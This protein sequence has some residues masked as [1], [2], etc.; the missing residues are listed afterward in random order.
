MTESVSK[1]V[2]QSVPKSTTGSAKK[3]VQDAVKK[4]IVGID[5]GTTNTV[6]AYASLAQQAGP[7]RIQLLQIDQLV[8]PGQ[9]KASALLPSVRYHGAPGEFAP[10]QCDLPWSQDGA[11]GAGEGAAVVIGQFARKLGAQV[12]GRLVVSAKSWL[13]HAGVDRLAPILPWGALLE[14]GKVSPVAASASYL[15]HVR[16]CW[17]KQFPDHPLA[18]QELVLTV[19]ASFDEGA[20]VLTLAAARQAGLLTL[21]LLEEPQAVFYDWLFR[22]QDT[23]AADL[24]STRLVL[25][26][27]VG[28]GT[29]DLSLIEVAL[30]DGAPQLTRVGVGNHLMLGG[31]NMDLAL[32]HLAE[33]RLNALNA[34]AAGA[35]AAPARL[36]AGE[37]SQLMER[38][39]AAKELLLAADAPQ[40]A[41]VTLL[42]TGNKL[43]KGARTVELQRAEVAALIVD[44]F[45]PVVERGDLAR[46]GRAGLVE[47]GLPY[48]SDPA[49]TRH[50]ATFLQQQ[51]A[52]LPA[53]L[54]DTLLLNGGVFRADALVRR[55]GDT[56]AAWRGAPLQ[57]LHN[58]DTEV[59][60]ARGA[61]A[62]AIAGQGRAPRIVGGAARSYF[63]VLGEDGPGKKTAAAMTATRRAICVLPRGSEAGSEI[64]LADHT[65]ALRI[66]QPVRFHLVSSTTGR[67]PAAG[68]L[69]AL[70][71]PDLVALPPIAL[72]LQASASGSKQEVR[73]QLATA[74]TELGTLELHC[75]EIKPDGVADAAP[76]QRWLLEFQLRGEHAGAAGL[77]P[78]A[79]EANMPGLPAAIEKIERIFGARA[80]H[81]AS[82]EVKQLRLQLEQLL[83]S[84]SHWSTPL[85][86]QLFDVLLARARGRRR[87]IEHERT[88]LNLAGYCLRPGFG[89]P[90]DDWRIQQLWALFEHGV[91]HGDD[92]AVCAEWW[93]LWRRVA[94]GLDAPSQLRLL[95]DFACNVQ[96]GEPGEGATAVTLVKG[97]FDDMLRLVAALERIP[98]DYKAEIGVWLLGKLPQKDDKNSA[99]EGAK[100]SVKSSANDG[101]KS[102]TG[103]KS[104]KARADDQAQAA[105]VLW[106]LGR[107]GARVPFY[108]NA[109]DVVA[110]EIVAIWLETMLALDWKRIDAAAFASAHIAR[111]SGDR[112]RDIAPALREHLIARLAA[113]A[114]APSWIAMVREVVELDLDDQRR[115]LGE[116]LPP[117]LTLIA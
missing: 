29:T 23:L 88:W 100:S 12:P 105:R 1:S 80:Q 21:R 31:D 87:S 61:V 70:D 39:R 27:D 14:V 41:A 111:M 44:G 52:D 5:L 37:L 54:P 13:S 28:G 60:V 99:N 4:Y 97:S 93:T 59:A 110:P 72:V 56:L 51:G 74:L 11:E 76:A 57:L 66:G 69:I 20:R 55:L 18:Q 33:T 65:F 68:E 89:A 7:G 75:V 103:V 32:A 63:L 34:S 102:R 36:S 45:F 104:G 114:S 17:D 108:G 35:N 49:I 106:A 24:A 42:G 82:K 30:Q 77:G 46:R 58:D 16:C 85:L 107:I 78:G 90:L 48:A 117:G 62:Y 96:E 71:D 22:H 25:V 19:P 81:V 79:Q 94:G 101:A 40:Q 53:Q 38:C 3:P 115:M 50:I 98:A 91:Q 95:A 109:D 83:G 9:V 67:I 73:V 64:V 6:V 47:F 43:I 26:V 8:A 92:G 113:S 15:D 116:A 2:S 86:R 10:G 112:A 84:R